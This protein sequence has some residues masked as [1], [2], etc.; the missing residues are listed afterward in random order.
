MDSRQALAHVVAK[1][2]KSKAA[3]SRELGRSEGFVSSLFSMH[4]APGV[5][6][7]ASIAK[8]CGY[9]LQLV[10]H[11]E[12]ITLGDDGEGDGQA[13]AQGAASTPG[14]TTGRGNG[15]R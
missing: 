1:G 6:L 12:T 2:G 9:D 14:T 4:R 5:D 7:M 11:G 3:L 8:A 13:R 10:G 15:K